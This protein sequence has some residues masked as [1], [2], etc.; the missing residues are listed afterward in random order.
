MVQACC[1]KL[2]F[3]ISVRVDQEIA[4]EETF[5]DNSINE[6]KRLLEAENNQIWS[7]HVPKTHN[8]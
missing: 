2:K 3:Q 4:N 1:Q 5:C 6:I 7:S 8:I